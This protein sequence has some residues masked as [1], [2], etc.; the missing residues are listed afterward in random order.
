MNDKIAQL[1]SNI[2]AIIGATQNL[3]IDGFVTKITGDTC[4]VNINGFEISDVR[5]KTTA[6]GK[7]NLLMIPAIGSQVLMISADGSI[8]NLTIIKCDQVSQFSYKENG[9]EVEI[10]SNSGKVSVKN[11]TTNLLTLFEDLMSLL[12]DLKV[13]TLS[14]VS[15]KPIPPT[16]LKLNQLESKFKTL[17]K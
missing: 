6:N 10:D 17:L 15:G 8:D 9:L 1:K 13:Y 12:K 14:G 7:D 11:E 2:K 3:P 16:I 5:L 4:T